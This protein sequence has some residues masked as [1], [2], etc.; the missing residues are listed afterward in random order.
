[1]SDR[2]T[3]GNSEVIDGL[4]TVHKFTASGDF[5]VLDTMD[6]EL[7]I[8]AGGGGGAAGGGGGGGLLHEDAHAVTPQ[9]YGVV[10]GP[11]G[12]AG[13]GYPGLPTPGKGGNSSFDGLVA[14][15]GGIG[16]RRGQGDANAGDGGCG[17]GGYYVDTVQTYG[18]NGTQGYDG[19]GNGNYKGSPYPSGGGGGMGGV[20]GDAT[21]NTVPGIAGPGVSY[22]ISGAPFTYARGGAG[23][24]YGSMAAGASGAANTGDGGG[25]AGGNA[26]AGAGGTGIVII[27]Y[28]TEGPP[29][30][31][32][33][34]AVSQVLAET[35]NAKGSAAVDISQVLAEVF[36]PVLAGEAEVS[37]ILAEQFSE[38]EPA[39][40]AVSQFFAEIFSRVL[41][42]DPCEAPVV[43][44]DLCRVRNPLLWVTW[45]PGD[46]T[47]YPISEVD[48]N[49]P[50]TYYDGYK[51]PKLLDVSEV[52]RALA[53]PNWDYEVGRWSARF[54]D[55][56]RWMRGLLVA[57]PTRY[58]TLRELALYAVS[59]VGRKAGV[60]PRLMGW[61]LVDPDLRL[62]NALEV[63]I[64]VKDVIGS[65][66]GWGLSLTDLIPKRRIRAPEFPNARPEVRDLGVPFWYGRLTDEG[67]TDPAPTWDGTAGRGAIYDAGTDTWT[68]GWGDVSY[69]SG[70]APPAPPGAFG[71][72][73]GAGGSFG[74]DAHGNYEYYAFVTAVD[75]L[76]QESNPEPFLPSA[77]TITLSGPTG[78][79]IA[80]WMASPSPDVV[81]YRCYLGWTYSGSIRHTQWIETAGLTCT[82]TRNPAWVPGALIVQSEITPGA[83]L[84]TYGWFAYYSVLAVMPDGRTA[85]SGTFGTPWFNFTGWGVSAPYRRPPRA[86]WLP[87]AGALGYEV[88]KCNAGVPFSQKAVVGPGVT[89][90]DDDG[91]GTGWEVC[92]GVPLPAGVIDPIVVGDVFIDGDLYAELLVAG[93]AISD[94]RHWYWDDG[95]N[96]IEVDTHAGEDFLIPFHAGWTARYLTSYRDLLGVDGRLY[97]RTVIY[98]RDYGGRTRRAELIAGTATLRVNLDGIEDTGDTSG[99]LVTDLYQQAAHFL[100][101]WLIGSY[102]TGN[103]SPPP[104]FPDTAICQVNCPSFTTLTNLR[105]AELPPDGYVGAVGIG[106]N[107]ERLTAN[108]WLTRWMR[109]GEFRLG[110]NRSWQ[111]VAKA[112]DEGLDLSTLPDVI[113][114][115]EVEKPTGDPIPKRAELVNE[116][117]YRYGPALIAGGS[118]WLGETVLVDAAS[119]TN[120][121][122]VVQAEMELH[123]V[124]QSDVA[125]H[126]AQ[127]YLNRSR[128]IPVYVELEGDLCLERFDLGDWFLYT[129]VRGLGPY[130]YIDAP[131]WVVGHTFLPRVRRV[132]LECLDATAV[133]GGSPDG[134]MGLG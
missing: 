128:M 57:D 37:Q 23:Q 118:G 47:K 133:F 91:L 1:M 117:T 132:R 35:F 12:S 104:M 87:V 28:L 53:G 96:P 109:S 84:V 122:E 85:L 44:E 32:T 18:G 121:R 45:K 90:F 107:G 112:I 63:E 77:T 10:V 17:G 54:A 113:D 86:E 94:I 13:A 9:T 68:M 60:V 70:V 119:Q 11:S 8:V 78:T 114:V 88:Y 46:G 75:S 62:T 115:S 59:N 3:G 5:V 55:T 34:I 89:Y 19:G 79:V 120:Y 71:L 31:G 97:R 80:T 7:L 58:W 66:P 40:G 67:S 95:T 16:G 21:S 41:P 43:G 101:A 83:S 93:C 116:V 72:T 27:R 100:N 126:V 2:A 4:Y 64:P 123:C 111:I 127:R 129:H 61:G 50:A 74:T 24:T 82:F 56:D 65:M 22:T 131:L 29:P 81:T 51:V 105:R 98:V 76:G 42:V 134:G 73:E 30:P 38:D 110:P 103:W 20:G 36:S 106:A 39:E 33:A 15:G 25:G 69:L 99:V 6:I 108:E 125:A 124:R 92:A 130:G 52:R 48:L 102:E 49:D 26:A 14:E